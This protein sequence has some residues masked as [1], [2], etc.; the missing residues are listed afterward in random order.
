MLNNTRRCLMQPVKTPTRT[1][2]SVKECMH[3]CVRLHVHVKDTALHGCKG[4][5]TA[6]LPP[7]RQHVALAGCPGNNT[8]NGREHKQ[9]QHR[10]ALADHWRHQQ[11]P[12][13]QSTYKTFQLRINLAAA[14]STSS[15]HRQAVSCCHPCLAGTCQAV[16]WLQSHVTSLGNQ[17][18]KPQGC[19]RCKG[20]VAHYFAHVLANETIIHR[21][22]TGPTTPRRANSAPVISADATARARPIPQPTCDIVDVPACTHYARMHHIRSLC[23][24]PTNCCAGWFVTSRPSTS[25]HR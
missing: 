24:Y 14:T 19:S 16:H 15:P 18:P 7:A 5:P 22:C 21:E 3:T 10:W 20:N 17:P 12:K 6:Y 11:D 9:K 13:R 2:T 1:C 23:H 25:P 4:L 8:V